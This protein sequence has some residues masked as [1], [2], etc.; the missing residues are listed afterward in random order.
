VKLRVVGCSPAWHNPGS[1]Q[2]GYLVEEGG[3][4]LLLDCGPGVLLRMREHEAWPHID[5]IAITHFHLD[6]WGDLVP[7][8]FGSLFGAGRELP[9][10]ELWL[11]PGGADTIQSLDSV[12]FSH[13]VLDVFEVHEY[14]EGEPFEAAG[15][16]LVALRLPHYDVTSFGFRVSANGSMLAYT[17]DSAPS[18]ALAE[19]G[20]DADLFVCEATLARPEPGLRGHLTLDEALDAYNQS[21]ARRFLVVHRP[22]ELPVPEGIELAYDGMELEV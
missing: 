19:L 21:S 16:E 4:L 13:C 1:A 8:A 3:R 11:P 9:K 10:P 22:T 6:H 20:R 18:P 7:W 17:G 15:F 2:S 14:V 12:L 5:A